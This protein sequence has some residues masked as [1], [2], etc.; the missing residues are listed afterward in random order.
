[1]ESD[2]IPVEKVFENNDLFK[3]VRDF[4]NPFVQLQELN[5]IF[6][7]TWIQFYELHSRTTKDE[8]NNTPFGPNNWTVFLANDIIKNKN[9]W[10]NE[11][12]IDIA[13]Q[14]A[15][16]GHYFVLAI[17]KND[18][19]CFFR[20][21]G[22]SNGYDRLTN[23]QMFVNHDPYKQEDKLYT[24]EQSIQY[25]NNPDTPIRDILQKGNSSKS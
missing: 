25:M 20:A 16:M 12:W 17:L 2:N 4:N 7:E 11:S 3:Y 10:I 1:M 14:Y 23:Y 9:D 6:P 22:G 15:G 24:V 8:I 5:V 13:L 21:A 18:N 19:K